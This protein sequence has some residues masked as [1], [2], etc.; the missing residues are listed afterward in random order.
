MEEEAKANRTSANLSYDRYELSRQHSGVTG[1]F[2]K[3]S[4]AY[5]SDPTIENYV[6]LRRAN[7]EVL[8]E[9]A[10]SW[11]IDWLFANEDILKR[12]GINPQTMAGALDADPACISEI[13]LQLME[14]LIEREAMVSAGETQVQSR[15]RAI[16]DSLVN[17]LIAMMLDSLDWN[18][19]MHI[20]RDLMVLIKHQIRADVSA[21]SKAMEVHTNRF[22]AGWIAAQLRYMGQP[23]SIRQ[24]AKIMNLNPSS[25]ARWF[26]EDEPFEA[27]LERQLAVLHSD[28]MADFR[29]KLDDDRQ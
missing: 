26:T 25:V 14:R 17:Y 22:N 9:I 24:V 21:E 15:G 7:P 6:R 18:D 29:K 16:G 3:L 20:P 27:E 13:S 8:I 19:E 10:T 12:F 23:G 2:N 1:D 28:L 5:K 11:S 4:K